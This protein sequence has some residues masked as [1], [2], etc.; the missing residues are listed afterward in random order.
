MHEVFIEGGMIGK[1]WG[2]ETDAYRD[3]LLRLDCM[4]SSSTECCAAR[5]ICAFTDRRIGVRRK[6]P[7]A[8]RS[9]GKAME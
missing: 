5:P 9:R 6:P 8:S 4:A 7:S 2:V 3:H 1:L